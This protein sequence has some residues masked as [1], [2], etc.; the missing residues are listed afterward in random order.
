MGLAGAGQVLV[1]RTVRDLVTGSGL[2]F[3]DYGQHQLK[4]VEG[5]WALF[6]IA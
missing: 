5:E 1:S 3:D 6:R 2:R 4:G